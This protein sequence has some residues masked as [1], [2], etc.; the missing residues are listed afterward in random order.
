MPALNFQWHFAPLI[1]DDIKTSTIRKERKDGRAHCKP[2][3]VLKLYTGM[4]TKQCKLIK[5]V[6]C[7]SYTHIL[8]W[9]P[10]PN[11]CFSFRWP[12]HAY[13]HLPATAEML[14]LNEGFNDH[15]EMIDWFIKHHGEKGS[16]FVE[17][18]G[19]HIQWEAL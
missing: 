13:H 3:D 12:D 19:W 8:L 6:R 9:G 14:A 10:A 1:R 4:R 2:G 16:D 7:I 11:G 18:T 5:E 17:F 15:I